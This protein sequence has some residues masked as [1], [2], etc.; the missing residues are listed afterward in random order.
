[1]L[2]SCSE[3][4]TWYLQSMQ[5]LLDPFLLAAHLP[6]S[7]F[8]SYSSLFR[9]MLPACIWSG[10]ILPYILFPCQNLRNKFFDCCPIYGL[11]NGNIRCF[12]AVDIVE[13]CIHKKLR[14]AARNVIKLRHCRGHILSGRD[15]ESP[16]SAYFCLLRVCWSIFK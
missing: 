5:R 9:H 2:F 10:T 15:R 4:L 3:T 6:H 11:G 1:M 14:L 16:I 7:L 8:R 12:R 13:D